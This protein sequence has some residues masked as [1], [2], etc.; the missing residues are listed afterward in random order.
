MLQ[1]CGK[2]ARECDVDTISWCLKIRCY[3][4]QIDMFAMYIYMFWI[5]G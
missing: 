3:G 4:S 5:I 1:A 2:E